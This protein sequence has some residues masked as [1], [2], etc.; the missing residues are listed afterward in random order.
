MTQAE[1]EGPGGQAAVVTQ[2][3][4]IGLVW[5]IPIVAAAIG[6]WLAVEE[7]RSRGPTITISFETAEGIVAGK[8]KI[9]YKAV[10]IGS[11]D[12]IAL[13]DDNSHVVATCSMSRE[14]AAGLTEGA[15]FW[16]VRPRIGAG[17]ISG[18]GTLVSGAYI[19]ATPGPTDGKP[20]RHFKG[21]ETPPVAPEEAPGLKLVFHA[22]ELGS[23][24][25][26]S[27]VYHRQIQVGTVEGY[28][29]AEDGKSVEIDAY[30]EPDYEKLVASNSRF[31]NASGIEVA[32]GMGGVNIHTES[33]AAL[34]EG[35]I[36]FDTPGGGKPEPPKP[37]A[38]FWLHASHAKIEAAAYRYGGLALV[39][40]GPQLGGLKVGDRVYYREEPVGAVVSHG[41]SA[42]HSKVRVHLN[43]QNR[44]ASLVRTNSVFWN[45]SGIS[46]DLGLKGLHV[47]T[48]SLE[49]LLSG[50]VAFATP[51][52]PG[53][54]VKAGSV[55][56]LH[57]EPKDEWTKW[58]PK[59]PKAE[60]EGT[61]SRIFHHHK[62]KDEKAAAADHD[63]SQPDPAKSHKHSF[64]HHGG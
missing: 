22:D 5:L 37:G 15:R 7:Y 3:R 49:A 34:L 10:E 32:V 2:K 9:K 35:G 59:K 52:S 23:V 53:A 36:A 45:A 20:A 26:G 38:S 12:A 6:V 25:V 46:A 29:L 47:H 64:F 57:P 14:H 55:F 62:G 33:L 41:L 50:G 58:S 51:D 42:D 17:G 60:H 54:Q 21:L 31:W 40:E 11:V 39:V 18:L 4:R 30:I 44:Y 13:S 28:R 19:T 43:V 8:T 16:V 27:H 63:A 1:S 61:L 56:K 48:E 24:D